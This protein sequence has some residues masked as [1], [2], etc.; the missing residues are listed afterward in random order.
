[1]VGCWGVESR[2][3]ISEN[4]AYMYVLCKFWGCV[5]ANIS[6]RFSESNGLRSYQMPSYRGSDNFK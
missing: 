3:L 5:F 4:V 6:C 1:M 2:I